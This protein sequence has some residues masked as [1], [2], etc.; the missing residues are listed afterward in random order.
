M[1]AW[2][3]VTIVVLGIALLLGAFFLIFGKRMDKKNA[4]HQEDIERSAQPMDFY[5]IDMKKM[6]LKNAGLPKVVYEDSNF[7][8][9][10]GRV[11]IIK[12]KVGSRIMNLVCDD[13]VFKTLLPKQEVHAMVSGIYVSS[14]KRIRGPVAVEGKR[15][16][17]GKKKVS[18]IDKLR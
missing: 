13:K 12:A 17:N 7:L 15:D 2:L 1:S 8:A 14:A 5:I 3:I 11:P 9:K 6:R 16:K 10:I 4:K 18:F